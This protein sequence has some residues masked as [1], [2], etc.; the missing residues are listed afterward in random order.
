MTMLSSS[1]CK[2]WFLITALL[3]QTFVLP[4][5]AR[6]SV[7]VLVGQPNVWSLE[8]AHYL[9]AQIRERNLGLRNKSLDETD[10]DPNAISATQLDAYRSLFEAGV[11]FDQGLGLKN[12]VNRQNL[13]FNQ[14]RR[15]ELFARRSA[16]YDQKANLLAD[17]GRLNAEKSALE[18]TDA[19]EEAIKEKKRE[20]N[21]TNE[22]ITAV[23][24]RIEN[25]NAEL[26]VI[27]AGSSELTS[28]E[29]T[30]GPSPLTGMNERIG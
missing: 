22:E 11:S 10:L 5:T 2:S 16:L 20:I 30:A 28:P 13:E 15:Q 12:S 24:Q 21:A 8:Q 1:K 23:N 17:R 29:K 3:A 4:Q 6:A 9:L 27:G 25:L 14:T 26:E 19:N 7:V 18:E